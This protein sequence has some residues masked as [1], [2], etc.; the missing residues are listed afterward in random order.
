MPLTIEN[1][2]LKDKA[3]ESSGRRI[4]EMDID[5]RSLNEEAR[6]VDIAITSEYPVRRWYGE[7]ILSHEEGA[8]RLD[9]LRNGGS[10]LFNH[11][12]DNLLGVVENVRLDADKVLRGTVRFGSDEASEMRFQQVKEGI[13]RSIS[14]G[15]MIHSYKEEKIED[16]Y[17]YTATDWEPYEVSFVTVPAD[18]TVGQ[19]RFLDVV[20]QNESDEV[21]ERKASTPEETPD[22]LTESRQ[23]T[24]V[25]VKEEEGNRHMESKELLK[26]FVDLADL[27]GV[28]NARQIAQDE[29]M[30]DTPI[31][32][33]RNLL[34]DLRSK[35]SPKTEVKDASIGMS[36][37]DLSKYSI[38]K[39]LLHNCTD[40]KVDAGFELE[41]SQEA[42][43][44]YAGTPKGEV[45]PFDVLTRA[46]GA[47]LNG[48]TGAINTVPT[49]LVSFIDV[50]RHA[51]VLP[52]MGATILTGLSGNVA[53][54]RV[55]AGNS[56]S[57]IS[58][59]GSQ[60]NA[61]DLTFDQV[62]LSPKTIAART[63]YT[64]QLLK[65]SALSVE[66]LVLDQL[67][68]VLALGLQQAVI[69]GAGSSGVPRGI[70][71][72]SGIGSVAMG[73]NGGAITYDKIVELETSVANA[74]TP[75]DSLA[76]LTN[77]RVRGAM[78][79]VRI[80][81]GSGLF[82]LDQVSKEANGYPVYA[83]NQIPN[84]LTKG[85]AVG[86]CSAVIFGNWTE[87]II[88]GWG[89]LDVLVNP[90]RLG[91]GTIEVEAMQMWDVG[92]KHP[93]AFSAILDVTT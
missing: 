73:T 79:T 6:T 2:L 31:E 10:L 3:I 68:K 64:T 11:N 14:A 70:L 15:Y 56:V 88:A 59:E 92:I 20:E 75:L 8:I 82:L 67:A 13:L 24:T 50:F 16:R 55:T 28:P 37:R 53:I 9:R 81:V 12:V 62:S 71:N 60:A 78:K 47:T 17:V 34:L 35:Q 80:D 89:G 41:L 33:Y 30:K 66:S 7:E 18:P 57:W 38:R 86:I 44:N 25:I 91:F 36:E 51:L 40:V 45:I 83:T 63:Q 39:L 4:L 90:F 49:D 52:A 29:F 65:Q 21:E 19:G 58:T 87:L 76:Y 85:S 61:S 84:N 48:A 26:E 93:A 46:L 74:N 23:D 77:S 69:N 54:P 5:T 72:T 32:Q 22:V 27:S 43:R 1:P 42:K